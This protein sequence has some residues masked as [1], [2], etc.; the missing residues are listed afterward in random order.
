MAALFAIA[1]AVQYNDP[2][3]LGWMAIYGA[4]CI[5]SIIAVA[6][7]TAPLAASAIVGLIALV[8]ALFWT[9]T[10]EATLG[11]YAH[12]FDNWEMRNTAIE[13]AREA[14][15]LF[16]VTVWMVVVALRAWVGVKHARVGE[17]A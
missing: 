5:V 12:M 6:R 2:D 17:P 3:P 11:V 13:E 10:S 8:W 9:G 4:A 16:I 7:G 15:G 14:S 1:A